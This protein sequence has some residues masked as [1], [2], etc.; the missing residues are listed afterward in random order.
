[1][2]VFPCKLTGPAHP[3]SHG[4]R[5][6]KL[7]VSVAVPPAPI[8]V[9]S[10]RPLAPSVAPVTSVSN[11]KGDNEMALGTVHKSPGIIN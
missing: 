1:M 5:P 2:V 4:L 7:L 6:N 3:W 11:N 10:Q 9:P 8:L